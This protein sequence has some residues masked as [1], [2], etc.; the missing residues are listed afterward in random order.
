MAGN[1]KPSENDNHVHI[2]IH[3]G[4]YPGIDIN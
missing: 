3:T 1:N 4:K 2:F